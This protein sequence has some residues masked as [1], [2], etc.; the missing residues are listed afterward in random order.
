MIR[1]RGPQSRGVGHLSANERPL[2][3][4]ELIEV[5]SR[6]PRSS[7]YNPQYT[8][9]KPYVVRRGGRSN[10]Y[11]KQRESSTVNQG[12]RHPLSV[13]E[14]DSVSTR[15]RPVHSTAKPLRLLCWLVRSYTDAGDLVCDPFLGSGTTAIACAIEGRRFV[16]CELEERYCELAAKRVDAALA[17]RPT[18]SRRAA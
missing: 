18:A 15:H 8:A 16:G 2:R 1:G 5:F 3:A 12:T 4:H 10:V 9:G 11:G 13:L 14:F 17:E 7:T 6:R